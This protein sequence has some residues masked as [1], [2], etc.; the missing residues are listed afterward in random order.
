MKDFYKAA[1]KVAA[2]AVIVGAVAVGTFMISRRYEPDLGDWVAN[3][4]TQQYETARDAVKD[5]L[6][7]PEKVM[8]DYR[9]VQRVFNGEKPTKE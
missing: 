3:Y 7:T 2:G 5:P 9:G 1:L 8:E 6:S 4:M